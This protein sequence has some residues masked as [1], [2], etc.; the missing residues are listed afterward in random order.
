MVEV[1][2]DLIGGSYQ[3]ERS[4]AR[5]EISW[6]LRNFVGGTTRDPELLEPAAQRVGMDLQDLG[7]PMLAF[8]HPVGLL[9]KTEHV[10]AVDRF[11]TRR[12]GSAR[13]SIEQWAD[14][15][16]RAARKDHRA[17]QP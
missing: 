16:C 12:G 15:Q 6:L 10:I 5:H 7:S 1:R 11:Q 3:I 17:L 9:E 14:L 13:R 4:R 8:D 2:S